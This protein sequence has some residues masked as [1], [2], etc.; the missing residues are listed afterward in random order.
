MEKD[1]NYKLLEYFCQTTHNICLLQVARLN[2]LCAEPLVVSAAEEYLS[3]KRNANTSEGSDS[4]SLKNI[5]EYEE[6][7]TEHCRKSSS[8]SGFIQ[9]STMEPWVIL[10]DIVCCFMDSVFVLSDGGNILCVVS[11]ATYL[12]CLMEKIYCV[13]FHGQKCICVV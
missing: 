3:A 4:S 8:I 7:R 13:L 12:C 10:V 11:W 6:S 1:E 5:S 9:P 2:S